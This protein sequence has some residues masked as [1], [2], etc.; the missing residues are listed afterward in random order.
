MSSDDAATPAPT[1]PTVCVYCASNLGDD[2][3]WAESAAEVGKG[4]AERGWDMVYGGGKE[5]LMGV[6]ADSAMAHGASVLGII[7]RQLIDREIAHDGIDE[8]VVV[9]N[10]TARKRMMAEQADA[11]LTLPGGV[12]TMEE[13]FETLT[14]G[15]LSLHDEPHGLLNLGGFYAP[16]IEFLEM[17]VARGLARPRLL[18]VLH[19]HGDPEPLLDVVLG[20]RTT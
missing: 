6:V 11:F 17:T 18:E 20:P 14:A 8:L 15:Y 1:R 10:M 12:G 3:S 19:V 7:T 13:F 4:L 5:G 9:E 16:L 2:P